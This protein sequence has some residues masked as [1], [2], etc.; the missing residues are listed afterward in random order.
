MSMGSKANP[1]LIGAFALGAIA[2][3]V[4]AIIAIGGGK[5]FRQTIPIVMYFPR[6]VAGLNVGAPVTFRGVRL[7]EVTD[8]FLGFDPKSRDVV[9]PVFAEL[10][11]QS[12]VN[13]GDAAPRRTR[14]VTRSM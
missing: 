13:L 10:F 2:L 5:L 12:I 11:P 1:K 9:I 14:S 6:S 3:L 4:I 7:G 8:I